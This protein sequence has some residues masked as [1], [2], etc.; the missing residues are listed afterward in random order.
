MKRLPSIM[1][2]ISW[3]FLA[4]SAQALTVDLMSSDYT[5]SILAQSNYGS[6][7]LSSS[8]TSNEGFHE[9]VAL[10]PNHVFSEVSASAFSIDSKSYSLIDGSNGHALI[11]GEW[12]FRT[13][14][15]ENGLS[16]EF[17]GSS[18]WSA[19]YISLYDETIDTEI[20]A[21]TFS[22]FY[23]DLRSTSLIDDWPTDW[24][25]I[26]DLYNPM[27]PEFISLDI[28][29][30]FIEEHVYTAKMGVF[31]HSS[32]DSSFLGMSATNIQIHNVPEPS[33]IFMLGIGLF[34][35]VK[36]RNKRLHS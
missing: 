30:L 26:L 25:D 16:V 13:L 6:D 12:T 19:G 2:M 24:S 15:T 28:N 22:Q 20:Y 18:D 35:L 11:A 10:N 36:L 7:E 9:L 5:Y 8:G 23:Y 21:M 33:I 4:P 27:G 1:I 31:A 32:W 3:I 17:T 34:G 14:G 29:H